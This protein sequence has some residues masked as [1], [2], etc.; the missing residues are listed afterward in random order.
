MEGGDLIIAC[1]VNFWT[2]DL[3]HT[4]ARSVNFCI[5]ISTS[6]HMLNFCTQL[7]VSFWTFVNLSCASKLVVIRSCLL[8]QV[9][10][11]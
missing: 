11:S 9:V 2:S 4:E 5:S 7:L 6:Y 3:V 1:T 10:F 8:V